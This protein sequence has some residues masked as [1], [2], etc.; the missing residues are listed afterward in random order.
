M[1]KWLI[2][3]ASIAMLAFA[4]SGCGGSDGSSSATATPNTGGEVVEEEQ[5]NETRVI[6]EPDGFEDLPAVPMPPVSE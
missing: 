6:N 5:N 4:M 3:L 1:S 2:S